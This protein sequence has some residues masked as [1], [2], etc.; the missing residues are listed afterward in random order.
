M[1]VEWMRSID[2]RPR[3]LAKMTPWKRPR[4]RVLLQ[5]TCSKNA[6]NLNMRKL[7][8]TS[9]GM[10]TMKLTFTIHWKSWN[11]ALHLS[12]K[13]DTCQSGLMHRIAPWVDI[14]SFDG[15]A[16]GGELPSSKQNPLNKNHMKMHSSKITSKSRAIASFIRVW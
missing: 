7:C 15:R 14:S 3:I 8:C 13:L 2:S 10:D 1:G 12:H 11:S 16:F 4:E 6:R 9:F 5:G